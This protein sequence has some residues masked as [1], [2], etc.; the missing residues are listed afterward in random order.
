MTTEGEEWLEISRQNRRTIRALGKKKNAHWCL[1]AEYYLINVSA[2]RDT[3]AA[4]WQ[5]HRFRALIV[6][7][8]CTWG[9]PIHTGAH[10]KH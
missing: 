2:L 5:S 8:D 4:Q 7:L 1:T 3:H 10:E 9:A 6:G